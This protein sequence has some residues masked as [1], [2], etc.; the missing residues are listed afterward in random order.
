MAED[1]HVL[2]ARVVR[3]VHWKMRHRGAHPID[4]HETDDIVQETYCRALDACRRQAFDHGRDFA[5]YVMGIAAKVLADHLRSRTRVTLSY[6]DWIDRDLLAS[7]PP[8]NEP[9]EVDEDLLRAVK[10]W[11]AQQPAEV[12][13]FVLHR[14]ERGISQRKVAAALGISHRRVRTLEGSVATALLKLV[15]GPRAAP[16]TEKTINDRVVAKNL[17]DDKLRDTKRTSFRKH[18]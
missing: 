12:A 16:L 11:K 15:R 4:G 10:A 14:Y 7:L 18:D 17:A 8:A 6:H 5:K 2:R 3:F 13:A 1:D 9:D